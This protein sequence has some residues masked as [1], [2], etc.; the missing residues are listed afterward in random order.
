[1]GMSR[2][3]LKFSAWERP[4]GQLH[5]AGAPEPKVRQALHQSN[6][7]HTD[8]FRTVPARYPLLDTPQQKQTYSAHTPMPTLARICKRL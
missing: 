1:M 6:T 3:G 5:P 7:V 2:A 4:R 8:A